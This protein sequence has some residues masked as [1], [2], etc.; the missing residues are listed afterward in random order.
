MK[1]LTLII[2]TS[3][4]IFGCK[5]INRTENLLAKVDSLK[6]EN[7]SL[8]KILT[9]KKSES[10]YWFDVEYDGKK[11]IEIGIKNPEEF[12]EN[13]LREKTELIP[14]KPTLGGTMNYDK[15]QLL[16]REWLI[17]DF[18]D[19]HVEGRAIYKYK[20]NKKGLLEFELLNSIEPE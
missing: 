5:D 7:D 17:A 19:G 6:I 4:Y 20:L 1:K 18:S 9:E 3:I 2:L 15:I 16:S 10:N 13:T 11:L 14:L 12:I 8:T